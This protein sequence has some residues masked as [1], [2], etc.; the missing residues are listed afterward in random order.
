M[1]ME[2]LKNELL[3]AGINKEQ[4]GTWCNMVSQRAPPLKQPFTNLFTKLN[5]PS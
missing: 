3:L 1:F 5:E 4:M 2:Y